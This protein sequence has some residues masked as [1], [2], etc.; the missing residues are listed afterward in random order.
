[1]HKALSY[2]DLVPGLPLS[3]LARRVFMRLGGAPLFPK[4]VVRRAIDSLGGP[5]PWLDVYGLVSTSKLR[6][7]GPELRQVMAQENPY[8]DLGLSLDKL[9]RWHPFNRALAVGARVMLPGLLL[10]AKG[11]RVAMHSS[12]ETRYPFLDEEVHAFLARLH[13]RWKMRGF[14]Q[15]YLLRLLAERY[16]PSKIAWRRKGLFRAALDSF[17]I[18]QPP[19]FIDQL[20]SPESLKRA[21]YFDP[22]AVAH[23]RT[24]FQT[25]RPFSTMRTGIEM[26]L[27]GVVSTQLWHHLFIDPRLADL[28]SSAAVSRT[29]TPVPAV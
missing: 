20:L 13:P 15:K 23:W 22:Q 27:V 25:M 10:H 21:G 6:F 28:P 9:R 19:A 7:F 14:K 1:V 8:A 11:D 3:Q 2:F 26:G 17:H 24:A 16:L 5:N 18:D 4:D 29:S 12:I